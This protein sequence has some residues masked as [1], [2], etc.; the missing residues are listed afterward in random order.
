MRRTLLQKQKIQRTYVYRAI[1]AE[2]VVC[3]AAASAKGKVNA[4]NKT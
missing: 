3:D 1:L 2:T 4:K